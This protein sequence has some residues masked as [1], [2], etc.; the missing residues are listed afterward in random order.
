MTDISR[1][2]VIAGGSGMIGRHLATALLTN[3]H[4]VDVLTRDPRR[5]RLPP[6]ARAVRWQA[7]PTEDLAGALAGAHAVIN[8]AGESI[9]PRP[10]TPGRKRAIQ[11][12]RLAATSMLVDA[13]SALAPGERPR[14]LVNASGTD[15]YVGRDEIPATEST[16]PGDDF[17]A[18]VCVAWEAGARAAEGLGIRV[19]IVRQA[20]V[21][22]HDAAVLG[23]LAL[24]FRLFA[25]GRLG[26]GRQ[27][28]SWIHIDDLV[29]LYR[30]AVEDPALEGI[31]NATA[32]EP[33]RNGELAAAIARVL[34]RPAWLPV[35]AWAIR[36]VLRDQATLVLGSRRA[37]PARAL[38]A[39]FEFRYPEL[40]AALREALGHKPS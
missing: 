11:D 24:P 8:L 4:V 30:W 34:G 13:M 40:E 23:L 36:L 12:S 26:S 2:V 39:G 29:A 25:G 9:G 27:W 15:V 37:V 20:F 32:P 35:P 10:W 22:A 16:P 31:V 1:R 17:L 14:V 7:T 38:G 6:G 28:F 21:L 5:S 3:G 19:V 33:C 18:R